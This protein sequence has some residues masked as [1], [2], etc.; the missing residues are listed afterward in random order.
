MKLENSWNW[1]MRWLQINQDALLCQ[2]M[3]EMHWTEHISS[4]DILLIVFSR[5]FNSIK[6]NIQFA[7]C[8]MTDFNSH[9]IYFWYMV[10]KTQLKH[11]LPYFFQNSK[12]L[13]LCNYFKWCDFPEHK[14][15]ACWYK[16]KCISNYKNMCSDLPICLQQNSKP[17]CYCYYLLLS[18][19]Q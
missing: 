17:T 11:R 19:C 10:L 16:T 1:R 18:P 12:Q 5:R 6:G 3:G 2:A 8:G 4:T 13:Y 9:V 15:M 14:T 7:D